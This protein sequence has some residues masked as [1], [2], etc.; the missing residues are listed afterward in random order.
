MQD[1]KERWSEE[2]GGREERRRR[3]EGGIGCVWMERKMERGR[4]RT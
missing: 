2:G 1:K 4:M 3:G